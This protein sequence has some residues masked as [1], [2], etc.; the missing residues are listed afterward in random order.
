[1]RNSVLVPLAVEE[2]VVL[3]FEVKV[4]LEELFNG[5]RKIVSTQLSLS[6]HHS[7]SDLKEPDTP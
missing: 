7:T 5:I 4:M 1:M 6:Q 3:G 2:C